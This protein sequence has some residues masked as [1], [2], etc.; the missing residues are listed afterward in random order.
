M[1]YDWLPLNQDAAISFTYNKIGSSVKSLIKTSSHKIK[2]YNDRTND[3]SDMIY[4]KTRHEIYKKS[5]QTEWRQLK[6]EVETELKHSLTNYAKSDSFKTSLIT[7]LNSSAATS[8]QLSF[9]EIYVTTEEIPDYTGIIIGAVLGG[10]AGIVL[11]VVFGCICYKQV[12]VKNYL[13]QKWSKPH[14]EWVNNNGLFGKNHEGESNPFITG[15]YLGHYRQYGKRYPMYDIELEFDGDR[16]VSGSGS[17]CVGDYNI[18]GIYSIHTARMQLDKTYIKG[19]GDWNE[20]LGHTVKIKLEYNQSKKEFSGPWYVHT[21]KYQ[22][23]GKW[24]IKL[25]N[26]WGDID[27]LDEANMRTNDTYTMR[28]KLSI[29]D[30]ISIIGTK[31]TSDYMSVKLM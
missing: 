9:T 22:G 16:N 8:N 31:E 25:S 17:D 13:K 19:T 20:N 27:D 4:N 7:S 24:V 26:D 29:N 2:K 15:T 3:K 12:Y 14:S 5:N 23:T 21:H 6:I 18:T 30:R 1:T 11:C 10:I 28:T